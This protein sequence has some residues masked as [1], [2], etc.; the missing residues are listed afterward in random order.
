MDNS[1]PERKTPDTKEI[2]SP[3]VNPSVYIFSD[4]IKRAMESIAA[5]ADT[6]AAALAAAVDRIALTMTPRVGHTSSKFLHVAFPRPLLHMPFPAAEK[7]TV[8][9]SAQAHTSQVA[10]EDIHFCI[11]CHISCHHSD[12]LKHWSLFPFPFRC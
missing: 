1:S 4:A 8:S 12:L 6:N 5:I 7:G 10:S 11:Y 2:T 3:S 9:P